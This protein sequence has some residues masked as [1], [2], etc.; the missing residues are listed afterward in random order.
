MAEVG[1]IILDKGWKG[2]SV[3]VALVLASSCLLAPSL[4]CLP[5]DY[6]PP[7]TLASSCNQLG[8]LLPQDLYAHHGF[9]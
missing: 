4:T 7:V 5:V 6:F 8:T 1:V 9:Y 3:D 2:L